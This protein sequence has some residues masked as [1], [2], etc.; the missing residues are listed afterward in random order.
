MTIIFSTNDSSRR[1]KSPAL[2]QSMA[3]RNIHNLNASHLK[4]Y[5]ADVR[6]ERTLTA[7]VLVVGDHLDSRTAVIDGLVEFGATATA[8]HSPADAELLLRSQHFDLVIHDLHEDGESAVAAIAA[9]A[10]SSRPIP[11]IVIAHAAA[12]LTMIDKMQ[13]QPCVVIAP[14]LNQETLF[15]IVH[16]VLAHAKMIAENTRLARQLAQRGTHDIVGSSPAISEL[17][18]RILR[19]AEGD[20]PVLVQGEP[21]TGKQ[22]V[23][24]VL[25]DLGS[26]AHRPFITLD[27]SILTAAHLERE[28]F[29]DTAVDSF[30]GGEPRPGRLDLA[31]GGTLVVQNVDEM[32][33]MIQADFAQV[34]RERRFRRLGATEY[35]PL[36]THI[37]TTT[38]YDLGHQARQGLFREE[39][40]EQIASRV[41]PTPPLQD[42]RD[43]IAVLTEHFL[44][45]IALKQGKPAKRI[46]AATMDILANY[47]WPGNVQELENLIERGCAIDCGPKLTPELIRPWLAAPPQDHNSS[48]VGMSLKEMERKL[49]ES[50][51]ARFAGNREKT[52]QALQIGLRTLSGKL[53]DYGY[54]PRGGPGSNQPFK[55]AA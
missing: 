49:I 44:R 6:Q 41:L 5:G 24:R 25:H 14:P 28:L 26:R 45:N 52:A 38:R 23:A 50:T 18:Q 51:F 32:A 9:L 39:L 1:F 43:D 27:C 17:R 33:F 15:S 31:A 46:P 55:R 10:T 12:P 7:H 37:I 42:H 29:G 11:E 19:C 35:R 3:H 8:V 40:L 21:G 48:E 2:N 34:L 30:R 22:L 47:A 16:Q 13:P 4:I 53:R 20:A 36:D 54:P